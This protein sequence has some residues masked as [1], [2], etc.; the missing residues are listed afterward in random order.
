MSDVLSYIK[1]NSQETQR[2][3]GL[4]YDQLEQLIKQAMPQGG[5]LRHRST[6]RKATR[7]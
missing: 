1:N 4:K 2:L 5:G 3:V 6:H 7:A